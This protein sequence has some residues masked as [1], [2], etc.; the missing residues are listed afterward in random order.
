MPIINPDL[1][2]TGPI[3]PGTY[4]SKILEVGFETSKKQ[5]PMVVVKHE[6]DVDGEKVPRTGYHVITG[7]G[8]FMFDQLLR[9]T[10]FADLAN[11]Y[12]DKDQPNPPFDTDNLVGQELFVV[13]EAGIYDGKPT[14]NIAGYLK[15]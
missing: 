9:A 15:L 5:N 2:Q 4:R 10:G 11:A 6:L 12:A 14:D 13:V 1:S 8:A 3:K 7:K